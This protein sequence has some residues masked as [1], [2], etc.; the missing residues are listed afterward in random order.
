MLLT[1]DNRTFVLAQNVSY[2][3]KDCQRQHWKQHKPS[4]IIKAS[5]AKPSAVH[6]KGD[7]SAD[8][9]VQGAAHDSAN[10]DTAKSEST[11]ST[12]DVKI[13]AMSVSFMQVAFDHHFGRE[14]DWQRNALNDPEAVLHNLH[15]ADRCVL[16]C[17][18]DETTMTNVLQSSTSCCL[19]FG[20]CMWLGSKQI[21]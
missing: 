11:K 19:E 18:C 5:P 7:T 3:G 2:C 4:C 10:G 17:K 8:A 16:A 20:A 13:N 9:A 14:T 1:V 15:G 12:M 21:C 6:S